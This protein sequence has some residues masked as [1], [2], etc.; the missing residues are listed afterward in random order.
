MTQHGMKTP[1]SRMLGNLHVRFGGGS[2]EKQ[3][4]LLAGGLPYHVSH[5]PG[6]LHIALERMWISV[7]EN[8]LDEISRAQGNGAT[9]A[10][11]GLPVIEVEDLT[12]VSQ[13]NG[14]IPEANGNGA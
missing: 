10:F 9:G 8:T 5:S 11:F 3:V 4:K 6:E 7:W 14:R 1:E 12:A 13:T 2:L